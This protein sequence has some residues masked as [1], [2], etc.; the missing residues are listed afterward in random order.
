MDPKDTEVSLSDI[1]MSP[2]EHICCPLRAETICDQMINQEKTNFCKILRFPE[3]FQILATLL[4]HEDKI[5]AER[6]FGTHQCSHLL[7][8]MTV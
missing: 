8:I 6:L 3:C 4:L 7:I 5:T 2:V 1:I